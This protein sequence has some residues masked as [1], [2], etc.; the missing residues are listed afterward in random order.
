MIAFLSMYKGRLSIFYENG[1]LGTYFY[2]VGVSSNT[3]YM[4]LFVE[5][6]GIKCDKNHSK[7]VQGARLCTNIFY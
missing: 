2:V 1:E 7:S 6:L 5:A 4:A 3:L